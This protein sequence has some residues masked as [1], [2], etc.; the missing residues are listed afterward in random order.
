MLYVRRGIYLN[1]LVLPHLRV[2]RRDHPL[3]VVVVAPGHR[4][5]QDKDIQLG[6][7]QQSLVEGEAGEK[8]ARRKRMSFKWADAT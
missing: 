8:E 4:H 2:E 6:L 5:H 7:V 3:E 1:S